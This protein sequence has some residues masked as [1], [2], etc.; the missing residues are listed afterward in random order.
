M[1]VSRVRVTSA[2]HCIFGSVMEVTSQVLSVTSLTKPSMPSTVVTRSSLLTPLELPLVQRQRIRPVARTAGDDLGAD[3][4]GGAGVLRLSKL[5][6][7]LVVF[8]ERDLCVAHK[9]CIVADLLLKLLILG[10][11]CIKLGEIIQ[12]LAEKCP[13]PVPNR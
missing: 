7:Q 5:R 10:L 6:A 4:G 9:L 12:S 13:T 11:E 2:P 1:A 8:L 3:R